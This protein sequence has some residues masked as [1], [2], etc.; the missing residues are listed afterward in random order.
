MAWAQAQAQGAPAAQVLCLV[1][2]FL[3]MEQVA[4]IASAAIGR[5]ATFS[6]A[7]LLR[8]EQVAVRLASRDRDVR[9]PVISTA[10]LGEVLRER[11]DVLGSEQLAMLR[12]VGSSPDRV[13]C[14]VG[15]A[16]S[17]KTTALAALAD[18]YQRDGHVV[19]RA[20]PPRV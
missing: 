14:V 1:E 3:A 15:H 16:G 9:S 7:E 18:A 13:V 10:S 8:H 19:L 6:T 11:A 5:P 4:P 20:A 2:R 17:G 12:A